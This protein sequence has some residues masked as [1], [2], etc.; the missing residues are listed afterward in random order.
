MAGLPPRWFPEHRDGEITPFAQAVLYPYP[1]PDGDYVMERGLPRLVPEGVGAG[2]LRGRT[3]VLSVG[4]NRSPL[5]LRRKFGTDA[6]VPVTAA[7]LNG[8]DVVFGAL[9]SYY[10]AV[11]ATGFPCP[12]ARAEL[13]IA[14][15]DEGQLELMHETEARGI[16][17]DYIRYHPGTVDHGPRPDGGDPVFAQPVHGYEARAGVFGLD[18]HP[19]AHGKVAATGRKFK[20]MGERGMLEEV[21]AL[22]TWAVSP[23]PATLEEWVLALRGSRALRDE[24]IKTMAKSAVRSGNAPWDTVEGEAGAAE[25]YL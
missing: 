15:L 8:V 5:Q 18:G 21:R 22:A 7:A 1:V 20:A 13:N 23:P 25:D 19:V 10:G 12:G 14:W 4:S 17:Y 24:V 6:V 9:V 16:A 3:P 2:M 11:P